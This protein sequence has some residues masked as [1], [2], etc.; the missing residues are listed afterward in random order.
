MISGLIQLKYKDYPNLDLSITVNGEEQAAYFR[1]VIAA[2]ELSIPA[3]KGKL[4][5]YATGLVKLTTGKMSS[6]TGGRL[7]QLAGCSMS[8]RR[9]LKMPAASQL[10]T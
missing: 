3:L 7:L 5:N 9:Q 8:L 1:G 4:F 10:T 6:R 2:S